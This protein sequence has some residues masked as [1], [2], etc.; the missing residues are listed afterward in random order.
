MHVYEPVN[1][2]GETVAYLSKIIGASES[3]TRLLL[4]LFAGA[5]LVRF[6]FAHLTAAKCRKKK[7][8]KVHF[9]FARL[10]ARAKKIS[11]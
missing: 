2:S 11:V 7:R 6:D 4:S 8:K 1:M 3:A 5:V 10:I 9:D